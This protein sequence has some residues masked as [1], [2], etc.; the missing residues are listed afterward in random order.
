M[1]GATAFKNGGIFFL[2]VSIHAP[3]AGSDSFSGKLAC[4]EGV[5][6][7]APYA[8]SDEGIEVPDYEDE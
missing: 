2:D 5:S 8:G 1:Q 7:H 6:I 4:V 3:Y